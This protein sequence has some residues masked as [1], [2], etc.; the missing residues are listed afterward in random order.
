M[1]SVEKKRMMNL[2]LKV[3]LTEEGASEFIRQK[4][5]LQRFRLAD[6]SEE[7]GI[8]FSEFSPSSLQQMILFD[9]VSKMEISMPEFS[10]SRSEIMDVSKVFVYSV[11]YKQYD[12]HLL[13]AI[14]NTDVIRRYNRQNPMAIISEK[15]RPNDT[16]LRSKL[17]GKDA[18]VAQI[19]EKILHPV[20]E[21]I[22]NDKNL[23][24]EEK[25]L[26]LLMSEKY[27]NR[28]GLF[29]WYIFIKFSRNEDFDEIIGCVRK[30]LHEYME[31]SVLAEYIAL[32]VM[33]LA[34]NNE[35]ENLKSV[36]KYLYRGLGEV[37][38]LIFDP[39]I[40]QKLIEELVKKN[41]LV[42]ISWRLGGGATAIGTKGKMQIMLYSKS[43]EFQELKENLDEKMSV[44]VNKKSLLDFYNNSPEGMGD[45]SLGLYYLSYLD[46]AC[47]KLN[48]RFES[49]V[50]QYQS[51]LTVINLVFYF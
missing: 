19:R 12:Q 43:D 34:Q 15:T 31:K 48:V 42:Y 8:S 1:G 45:A 38:T 4:K 14:L 44:D 22:V 13:E 49:I 6:N 16:F 37:D 33:E 46:E 36:A 41:K 30:L 23:S 11:L 20:W 9:Y 5:R 24:D 21:N 17:L 3:I 47:K 26:Q 50:N 10:S 51:D 29:V 28:L 27:I 18:F 35:N 2:P 7:Y 25:N 32:M 40:R 39:E